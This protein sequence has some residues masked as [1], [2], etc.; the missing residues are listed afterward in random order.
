MPI[1]IKKYLNMSKNTEGYNSY[2]NMPHEFRPYV[3]FVNSPNYSSKHVNTDEL[4]FR[5]S[6]NYKGENLSLKQ[7]KQTE[8]FCNVLVGGSSAFGMGATSDTLTIS[9]QLSKNGIFCQNFGVRGASSQQEL[10]IFQNFKRFLPK[11]RNVYIFSGVNDL[12]LAAEKSS[13]FYP[14]FG[15][16]YSEDLRFNQFWSQYISFN[17]EKWIIG[18][19]KFF[20]AIDY[21]CKKFSVFK[22]VFAFLSYVLPIGSVYRKNKVFSDI[23]FEKKI[24][25]LRDI[26]KNDFECWK[27]LSL[28]DNFKITYILQPGIN[29]VSKKLNEKEK[30]IFENQRAYLGENYFDKFMNKDI[31]IEHKKFLQDQCDRNEIKFVD[32]N[33]IFKNF[34]YQKNLFLDLCHLSDEGNVYLTN[35]LQNYHA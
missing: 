2:K 5:K 24:N 22:K 25:Y 33:L 32:A 20:F 30:F 3:M 17:S 7:V 16:I 35:Y 4:G 28:K 6:E 26:I 1:E 12:V 27:A 8:K 9:S 10:I 21:L 13:F 29:W 23:P 15:G 11:I 31:Y 14:E 34:D 18:K 19:N